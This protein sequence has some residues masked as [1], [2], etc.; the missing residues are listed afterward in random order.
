MASLAVG[1]G[2]GRLE[3][4]RTAPALSTANGFR[5]TRAK[6]LCPKNEFLVEPPSVLNQVT[7][8]V[9]DLKQRRDSQKKREWKDQG[10]GL[11]L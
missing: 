10:S 8:H 9:G 1:E 5:P 3:S 6:R 4:N 11:F 7:I 2:A